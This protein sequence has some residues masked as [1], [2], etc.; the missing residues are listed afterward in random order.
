MEQP[1][2]LGWS[3]MRWYGTQNGIAYTVCSRTNMRTVRAHPR[4]IIMTGGENDWS[5]EGKKGGKKN[6]VGWFIA[7][8]MSPVKRSLNTQKCNVK[9][10]NPKE[11][12]TTPS[13]EQM[14]AFEINKQN[15]EHLNLKFTSTWPLTTSDVCSGKHYFV[16]ALCSI[17]R[18]FTPG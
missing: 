9:K 18:H 11:W 6:R 7:A 3:D 17:S 2:P 5:A 10:K 13:W 15:W 12:T 1:F 4:T 14:Q 16:K 8:T